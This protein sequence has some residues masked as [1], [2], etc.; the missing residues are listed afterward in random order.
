MP[1]L[2]FYD[3][4]YSTQERLKEGESFLRS[5]AQRAGADVARAERDAK[6][7]SAKALIKADLAEAQRFGFSGTPGFLINGVSLEGAY[8]RSAFEEII[9]R[10]LA[11]LGGR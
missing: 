5:A 9:N 2:R 8:P 1:A 11:V 4:L 3:E 7:D 10:H 6:G